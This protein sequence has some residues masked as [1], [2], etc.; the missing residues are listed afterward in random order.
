MICYADRR[1]QRLLQR[2]LQDL[3]YLNFLESC[4]RFAVQIFPPFSNNLKT[5]RSEEFEADNEFEPALKLAA[6]A[7]GR[8]SPVEAG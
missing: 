1:R 2:K 4:S 5:S 7:R 3:G 6:T 8:Y